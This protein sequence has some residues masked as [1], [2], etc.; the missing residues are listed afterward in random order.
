MNN[1]QHIFRYWG[2]IDM[3]KALVGETPDAV[4]K[5][6]AIHFGVAPYKIKMVGR[7]L[8]RFHT[9]RHFIAYFGRDTHP[10]LRQKLDALV[11][12]VDCHDENGTMRFTFYVGATYHVTTDYQPMKPLPQ[13]MGHAISYDVVAPTT[14]TVKHRKRKRNRRGSQLN[15]VIPPTSGTPAASPLEV[16]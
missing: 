8:T 5:A 13:D 7:K 6:Y 16:R 1:Q 2:T 15:I 12:S 3:S 14:P 4:K 10:R 11:T 9:H